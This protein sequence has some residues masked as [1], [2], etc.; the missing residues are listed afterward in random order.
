MQ[1]AAASL[2][3]ARQR[4][5]AFGGWWQPQTATAAA[6][7]P[8]FSASAAP[9]GDGVGGGDADG[10]DSSQQRVRATTI[11]SVRLA[12]EVV[13]MAD[14]QITA[15]SKVVKHS[16]KKLRRLA[17]GAVGGFAGNRRRRG[18]FF[19]VVVVHTHSRTPLP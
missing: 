11:L 1:R 2:L 12:G 9:L 19:F 18:V 4:G 3:L 17:G 10:R 6:G 13:L 8:A 14:G 5:C 7:G 16:A 15:G